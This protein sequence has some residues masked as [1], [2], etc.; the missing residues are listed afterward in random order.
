MFEHDL[1]SNLVLDNQALV[2]PY[3][4]WT[5]LSQFS[6]PKDSGIFFIFSHDLFNCS[7]LF[8][9]FSPVS[10]ASWPHSKTFGLGG[11]AT[12]AASTPTGP[13]R[14]FLPRKKRSKRGGRKA[15]LPALEPRPDGRSFA[16][17]NW[18]KIGCSAALKVFKMT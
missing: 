15:F 9:H 3:L 16:H 13:F 17:H 4:A 18:A 6:L 7:Y 12:G 10:T 5:C 8:I 14:E 1:G 11:K 2:V